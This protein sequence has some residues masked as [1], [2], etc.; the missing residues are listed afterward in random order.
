MVIGA[1]GEKR[2]EKPTKTRRVMGILMTRAMKSVEALPK[3][4][5]RKDTANAT[6]SEETTAEENRFSKQQDG[7]TIILGTADNERKRS[8]TKTTAIKE[9]V[10][11]EDNRNHGKGQF[12]KMTTATGYKYAETTRSRRL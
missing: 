3:G 11:Y 6:K 8:I 1:Y 9:K 7:G 2:Q 12:T 5:E 4:G 10:N